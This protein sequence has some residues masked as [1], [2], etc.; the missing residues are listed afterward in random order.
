[1]VEGDKM[2]RRKVECVENALVVGWV[3]VASGARWKV[4]KECP[5]RGQQGQVAGSGEAKRG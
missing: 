4:K 2:G 3:R 1:M 5:R